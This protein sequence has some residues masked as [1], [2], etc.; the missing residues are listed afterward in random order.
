MTMLQSMLSWYPTIFDMRLEES[1]LRLTQPS[2]A[3][4]GTMV[5]NTLIV[6]LIRLITCEMYLNW[7]R[8]RIIFF[9][10]WDYGQHYKI[11]FPLYLYCNNILDEI[12]FYLLFLVKSIPIFL[13]YLGMRKVGGFVYSLQTSW[14]YFYPIYK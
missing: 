2:L 4:L 3:E 9:F 6:I 12:Y 14:Y 13:S 8:F 5:E 11:S 1:K 10:H 7:N